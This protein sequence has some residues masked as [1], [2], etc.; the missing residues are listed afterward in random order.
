VQ[1]IKMGINIY[2]YA[3][4]EG[5]LVNVQPVSVNQPGKAV[6]PPPTK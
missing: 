2:L 4:T 6:S 5:N 3:M 1:A